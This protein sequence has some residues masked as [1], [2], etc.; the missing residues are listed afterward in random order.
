LKRAIAEWGVIPFWSPNIL[1]GYPFAANPLSGLWYPPGWL[2]L[3]LPLPMGFNL[4]VM[5]HLLLGGVGL[6]QFLRL[7]GLSHPG[8]LFGALAFMAAPKIFAQYG[9]GHLTLVYA[10]SWTPWLLVTSISDRK[11]FWVKPGLILALI[12]LAD[13]R[14]APYAGMLW[15]FWVVAH[16][17]QRERMSYSQG[18]K[19]KSLISTSKSI[20]SNILIAALIAAPLAIPLMEYTRLSTRSQLSA[21]DIFAFSLPPARTLGLI[22]PDFG[23]NH[24]WML[25]P[26]GIVLIFLLV[27]V[28]A[29]KDRRKIRFWLYVFLLSIIFSMGSNLPLLPALAGIPGF[30][31]LR[32]PAR[33]LFLT[34]LAGAVL[35]A[36]G[37]EAL[38]QG[39]QDGKRKISMW[40]VGLSGFCVIFSISVGVLTGDWA[41]NFLWGAAIILVGTVWVLVML[42]GKIPNQIWI[43]GLF[44]IALLDWGAVNTSVIS[45]RNQAIDSSESYAVAADLAQKSGDF[46]TYSPS[47]SLPQA[48]SAIHGLELADGVDPLQ[49][50]AY[51]DYMDLAT[52]VPRDG[53]SITL[54][55]FESG[56]IETDNAGYQPDLEMLGFL[57]VEYIISAFEIPVDGLSLVEEVNGVWIY[58]NALVRPRAW[59]QASEGSYDLDWDP[60]EIV[61]WQ[62]NRILVKAN[63]PGL[64]M[65]S[66]IAYPGWRVRV[67]DVPATLE[68]PLGILRGAQIPAGEH[69]VEFTFHPMS[70]Y[71]GLL[72]C[73]LGLGLLIIRGR[74]GEPDPK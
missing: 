43:V 61:D 2:A 35:A 13:P 9:A 49:L 3:L 69:L 54:P 73:L 51:S 21:E 74:V 31:L 8:A 65:L 30:D 20:L 42:N 62:P 46:R 6:Y 53:Y 28:L 32:V 60:A 48:V 5:A 40:L 63:G 39:L 67:D 38:I 15:A 59:V 1:S 57:N 25:Y 45:F 36:F 58:E 41:A 70:V 72:C 26:G 23:G 11:P 44:G 52:G 7:Q 19:G 14:W 27:A 47:Y 10:V 16:R 37:V 68:T 33:A 71:I 29:G 12:F 17:H 18:A 66:E 22:F 24:E 4:L 34:G 56:N 50:K 64:V 55:P